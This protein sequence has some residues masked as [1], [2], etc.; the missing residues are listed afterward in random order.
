MTSEQMWK[1]SGLDGEYEA[2]QF[3]SDPDGLAALVLSGQKRATS[4]A[5]AL[6]EADGEPLP[7]EGEYSV[8]LNSSDEAV[9]IIRDTRVYV[10]PYSDI[11]EEYAYMEG[12][13]NRSLEYW[14]EVH[15]PFFEEEMKSAGLRF[16][17]DMPIV[18]EEFEVIYSE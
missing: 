18:C 17:E 3:G 6:Y 7:E 15:R 4:S 9:C 16:S 2:W 10:C 11:S 14:R 13:G 5:L 1:A 8:I 12:E